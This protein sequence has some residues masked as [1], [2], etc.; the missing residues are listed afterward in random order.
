MMHKHN[1]VHELDTGLSA[2]REHDLQL[3]SA[4]GHRFLAENMLASLGSLDHPL[5]MLQYQIMMMSMVS[6][7]APRLYY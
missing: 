5:Q 3:L 7:S 2:G 4:A 6:I 1:T